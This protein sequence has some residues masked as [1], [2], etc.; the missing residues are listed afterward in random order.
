MRIYQQTAR[1]PFICIVVFLFHVEFIPNLRWLYFSSLGQFRVH[2][3][4]GPAK[5]PPKKSVTVGL[6]MLCALF[7]ARFDAAM[8]QLIRTRGLAMRLLRVAAPEILRPHSAKPQS[9]A[10][11]E[12]RRFENIM[13]NERKRAYGCLPGVYSACRIVEHSTMNEIRVS[14]VV[15]ARLRPLRYHSRQE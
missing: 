11:C 3:N 15:D 14:P 1:F 12:H 13:R 5:I 8:G 2:S 9:I 4:T 6:L 10:N 7:S